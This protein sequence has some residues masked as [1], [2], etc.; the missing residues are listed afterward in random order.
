MI[1]KKILLMLLVQLVSLTGCAKSFQ[2][3]G[4]PRTLTVS[5]TPDT[6]TVYHNPCTGWAIYTDGYIPS[7]ASAYYSKMKACGA[8]D[9]A[10]I[11]YI[12]LPWALLE[13]EEGQYA[14]LYND[15]FKQL[16]SGAK[17]RNLKLAFRVYTENKDYSIRITPQYVKDAGAEG[18]TVNT[19]LWTP[20]ADDP[21]FLEKLDKFIEALG[22]EFN[23]PEVTDFVDGFGLGTWGE[24]FD[25]ACKDPSNKD[26]VLYTVARSYA[27]HFSK[28]IC[29]INAHSA[30]GNS[31][32]TEL[33]T[34]DG[35]VFRHD[36][37]GSKVWFETSQSTLMLKFWPEHFTIAESMWWLSQGPGTS[38]YT[39]EGFKDWREV[40][41]FTFSEAERI[42][43]NV[44]D[45]R[46]CDEARLL[47]M[48]LAPDLVEDFNARGGYRLAPFT[49]KY[50]D[51]INRGEETV[52]THIWQNLGWGVLPNGNPHWNYKYK[53]AFALLSKDTLKPVEINIDEDVEPSEWLNSKKM[54]YHSYLTFNSETGEYL[55]AVGIVDT[56]RQNSIGI[57]LS[58]E[59]QNQAYGGW[60]PVGD[61]TLK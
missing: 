43:A 57:R 39:N 10:S 28:V 38:L 18:F 61:V 8:L 3:G 56:S 51:V 55:L 7:S 46:N 29:A 20:Y 17:E 33:A 6:E 1:Q 40:L 21:V 2:D 45:L 36:A 16:I 59:G 30:I 48:K 37:I 35:Y 13:P 41:D 23:D 12:R 52:V 53:V 11:L 58:V 15:E 49:V 50:T 44:L 42:H 24:G 31:Q 14:W 60:L 25:V 26:Y 5:Y 54:P 4:D 27:R 32:L 19:G 34:S 47:W 9:Y 22:S